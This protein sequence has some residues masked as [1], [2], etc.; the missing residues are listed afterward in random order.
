M[1]ESKPRY[2]SEWVFFLKMVVVSEP[3]LCRVTLVSRNESDPYCFNS[4]VNL[5]VGSIELRG[6]WNFWMCPVGNAVKVS[7]SVT[8]TGVEMHR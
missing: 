2:R 8:R 1:W 3:S 6:S 4:I 5:M 7:S